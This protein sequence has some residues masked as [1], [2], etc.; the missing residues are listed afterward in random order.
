MLSDSVLNIFLYKNTNIGS[1]IHSITKLLGRL[2]RTMFL[3]FED[4]N[5]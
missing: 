4:C 1:G 5:S 2:Y 3:I